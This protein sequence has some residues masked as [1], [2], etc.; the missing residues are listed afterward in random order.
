MM[1]VEKSGVYLAND[2]RNLGLAN[3][4][5]GKIMI[6]AN[7]SEKIQLLDFDD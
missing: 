3:T 7:N 6:A 1:P 5:N 4:A 2:L